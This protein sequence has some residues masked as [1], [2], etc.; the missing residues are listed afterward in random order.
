M[1]NTGIYWMR[2]ILFVFILSGSLAGQAQK[3]NWLK[4]GEAEKLCK[5]QPKPYLI[6]V[7]TDWCG[8]CKQMDKTTYDDP[9]VISFV[10]RYFYPVKLNAESADTLVFRDKIYA[11]FKNGG[12][13]ISSLALELLGEK[14]SY[15]TTVFLSDAEK[16]NMVVPGYM[17]IPKMQGFMVYF[18]EHANQSTNINDFLPDFEAVFAPEADWKEKPGEYW[19]D[20]KQ[21]EEK[22]K[23]EPRKILLFLTASWNNSCKM[24]ERLVFPDSTFSALAQEH[25]YC[26]RLD[27]QS[28]D[29]LTFMTH[30]F[31]NAGV[32]NN[33]LHQLAIALS[34][35]VLKVPAIYLFDEDGKLMERLYYY[36]DRRRGEMILD[37]IG[38][39]TFK[40]MSWEDYVKIR[41]KEIL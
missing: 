30:K 12:K 22:R 19:V 34:D 11:P 17:D 20:F 39:D 7:Y 23:Q 27:V 1:K 33:N 24:M 36:L 28:R 5:E 38:S 4:I 41:R 21:L 35:K 8:W 6:D 25:F 2:F 16:I 14:L 37:Y 15:P 13:F 32:A 3:I 31:A 18:S 26:L 29:S 9:V 40:N 10:N